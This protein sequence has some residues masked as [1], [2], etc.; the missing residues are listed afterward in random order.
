MSSFY[1]TLKLSETIFRCNEII[2][3]TKIETFDEKPETSTQN[4]QLLLKST[5]HRRRSVIYKVK[6]FKNNSFI[7]KK[8]F[9]YADN[10]FIIC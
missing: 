10:E 9:N 4:V 5:L 8:I 1:L 6:S 2:P 7:S 3:N